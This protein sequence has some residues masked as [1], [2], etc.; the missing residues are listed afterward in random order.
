[1][2]SKLTRADNP[3]S[4]VGLGG[5]GVEARGGAGGAALTG[6]GDGTYLKIFSRSCFASDRGAKGSL[7][8]EFVENGSSVAD[9]L[10]GS[11]EVDVGPLPTS[12]S[13][14]PTDRRSTSAAF[15]RDAEDGEGLGAKKS[16][17]GFGAGADTGAAKKSISFDLAGEE[18]KSSLGFVFELWVDAVEKGS[19]LLDDEFESA[20]GSNADD[21]VGAGAGAETGAV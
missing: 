2:S 21:D 19:K 7:T 18:K 14:N 4:A 13:E 6:G 16:S 11:E 17:L 15:V 20:N 8:E 1:M 9:A 5:V 10:K 3:T 12:R